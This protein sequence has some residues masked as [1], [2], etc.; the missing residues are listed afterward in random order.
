MNYFSN[1]DFIF[2]PMVSYLGNKRKLLDHIEKYIISCKPK[3][4]LDGFCGSG[5]VSRLLKTY[6]KS[7]IVND[8][9][10]Y[11]IAIQKA[12]LGSL[13]KLDKELFLIFLE[14]LNEKVTN[15]ITFLVE[16]TICIISKYYSPKDSYDIK[17]KE[18][19]FYTSENGLRIDH[20]ISLLHNYKEL[21]TDSILSQLSEETKILFR[22]IAIG[23]LLVKSSI[24]T[25]TSGVFKSFY[26]VNGIGHWG[27]YKE[28]DLQ[29]ILRPI[30]IECPV[31][32]NNSCKIEYNT[33]T[34]NEFW[35]K[36]KTPIDFVYYDPPY[37]QHPYGS[38]YFML[39]V[40]YF[41]ITKPNYVQSLTIDPNSISGIPKD[42]TRSD[43]NYTKSAFSAFTEMI[44]LTN[45]NNIL[46]SYND[47]GMIKKEDIIE[48]LESKG[49]EVS[50]EEIKY[51]NLNS[52][53]NKKMGDKVNEYLFY[54]SKKNPFKDI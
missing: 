22:D 19:C 32:N 24:H 20:Y 35:E 49:H 47:N 17:E 28:H 50:I 52:R 43:F 18:R 54:S 10:P 38:N 7:L 5:V 44:D 30:V 9:E 25:N 31:F 53:P 4:A 8:I 46:I 42:W 1:L 16:P 21:F 3:S 14:R 37:N 51:K 48:M 39:N 15:N 27:G 36:Q 11:S 40:I 34:I 26:K 45:A 33:G 29:R 41:G 13:C 2:Q 12:Y 6:T 23:N